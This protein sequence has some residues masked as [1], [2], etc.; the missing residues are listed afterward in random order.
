MKLDIRKHVHQVSYVAGLLDLA[1]VLK[2]S[3]A[4]NSFLKHVV[5]FW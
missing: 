4:I 1:V 2:I 3:G 5:A